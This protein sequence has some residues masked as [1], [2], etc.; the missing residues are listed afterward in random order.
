[1]DSSHSALHLSEWIPPDC[2]PACKV[3]WH[4]WYFKKLSVFMWSYMSLILWIFS[5]EKTGLIFEPE[6][7]ANL[8]PS[9]CTMMLNVT[10]VV[11]NF[12]R[13]CGFQFGFQK[14]VRFI[15]YLIVIIWQDTNLRHHPV[16]S[17][18]WLHE[19]WPG[20]KVVCWEL[21]LCLIPRD[22]LNTCWEQIKFREG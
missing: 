13:A 7:S 9:A 8:N 1:M 20:R 2:S 4:Q 3:S 18:Q 16:L 15:F 19:S 6:G 12:L 21:H 10:V 11:L 14:Q 17:E 5:F 22:G